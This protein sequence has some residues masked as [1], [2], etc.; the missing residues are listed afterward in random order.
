MTAK[1][2]GTVTWY[3]HFKIS[4]SHLIHGKKHKHQGIFYFISAYFSQFPF[5]GII[6]EFVK[7]GEPAILELF[8][9]PFWISRENLN[10]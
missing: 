1:I 9:R 3:H 2:I 6:L 5:K 4:H 8:G 10:Q 7:K